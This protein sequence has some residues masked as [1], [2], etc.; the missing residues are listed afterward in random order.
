MNQIISYIKN[1]IN[2]KQKIK[3]TMNK[4]MNKKI[5]S[6]TIIGIAALSLLFFA[7]FQT[8]QAA[9][10]TVQGDLPNDGLTYNVRIYNVDKTGDECTAIGD[11]LYNGN[12]TGNATYNDNAD[13]S[14]SVDIGAGAGTAY[15][16]F[17]QGGLLRASFSKAISGD[18]EIITVDL[19]HVVGTG[20]HADL[21]DKYIAVCSAISE[22]GDGTKVSTVDRQVTAGNALDQWYA[23]DDTVAANDTMYVVLD[24]DVGNN[25]K[26][27][28]TAGEKRWGIKEMDSTGTISTDNY[29]IGVTWAPDTKISSDVSAA[30]DFD[31]LDNAWIDVEDEN[32]ASVGGGF[33]EQSDGG[34]ADDDYYIY[35]DKP[36]AGTN[37][38]E[39]IINVIDAPGGTQKITVWD[40]VDKD[41]FDADGDADIDM[42]ITNTTAKGV[43][44]DADRVTTA[45]L[46]LNG[47]GD[48]ITVYTESIASMLYEIFMPMANADADVIAKNGATTLLTM[49]K[50]LDDTG[51]DDLNNFDMAKLSGNIHD[52]FDGTTDAITIYSDNACSSALSSEAFTFT[53]DTTDT[54]AQY[55]EGVAGTDYF[56]K[57]K[58]D[59]Y[60]ACGY[61]FDPT[62]QAATA[63][64]IVK[65]SGDTHAD[66]LSVLIDNDQG[67]TISNGDVYLKDT[68]NID[69][70]G[71]WYAYVLS[72]ATSGIVYD[73]GDDFNFDSKEVSL[74]WDFSSDIDIDAGSPDNSLSS[75][76]IS[77]AGG[78]IHADMVDAGTEAIQTKDASDGTTALSDNDGAEVLNGGYALYSLVGSGDINIEF[79]TAFGGVVEF[80][81]YN[82]AVTGGSPYI[83]EP[84]FKV[85]ATVPAS[86]LGLEI[87][88]DDL[89]GYHMRDKTAAF[90]IYV[91]KTDEG[92]A[93]YDYRAYTDAAFTAQVLDIS[94]KDVSGVAAWGVNTVT[95]TAI[96]ADVTG[97]TDPVVV[98]AIAGTTGD[99]SGTALS[100]AT[101]QV[102]ANG[103]KKY[104][105]TDA[106]KNLVLKITDG[107]YISCVNT[108]AVTA[109]AGLNNAYS[110]DKKTSGDVDPDVITVYI[111]ADQAGGDDINQTAV[112]G[113]PSTYAILWAGDGASNISFKNVTPAVVLDRTGK[114]LSADATVNV[115]KVSGASQ[116][117]LATLVVY[118]DAACSAAVSSEAVDP[119]IAGYTQY[120]EGV[121]STVYRIAVADA[122]PHTSCFTTG[123]TP[124]LQAATV[125]FDR[126]LSGSVPDVTDT[127][128]DVMSVTADTGDDTYW[129]NTV[130]PGGVPN[131][132]AMYVDDADSDIATST[133]NFRS[134]VAGGGSTLVSTTKD[135]SSADGTVD[136]SVAYGD[137]HADIQVTGE[138]DTVCYGTLPTSNNTDCSTQAGVIT[139]PTGAAAYE[140]YFEQISGEDTYYLQIADS[141]TETYYS[142]NKLTSAT[143]GA[144]TNVEVDGKLSGIVTE[145]YSASVR[146]P[147]VLIGLA[148][149]GSVFP[150]DEVSRTYSYGVTGE[151][152]TPAG[153]YRMYA[154]S[155]VTYDGTASKASYVTSV[156]A[157][158]VPAADVTENWSMVDGIKVTVKDAGA[159]PITDAK[160]DIYTCA[161]ADPSACTWVMG[162]CTQP[163][164]NCTRTGEGT[165]AVAGD[166]LSGDYY[167]A[168]IATGTYIQVRVSDPS[169]VFDTVYSPNSSD[170]VNS[171]V[172]SASAAINPIVVL[173]DPAPEGSITLTGGSGSYLSGENLYVDVGQ[174]VILNV[175]G[176]ETGLT[177]VADL[178]NIGGG[179]TQAV[180]DD[181]DNTYS[182]TQTV[183][184]VATGSKAITVTI[185]DASSNTDVDIVNVTVDNTAPVNATV[186]WTQGGSS[187]DTSEIDTDGNVTWIWTAGSD[188]NSGL[189]NY[190][191]VLQSDAACTFGGAESTVWTKYTTDVSYNVSGLTDG[192]CYRIQVKAVDNVGNIAAA[193][194]NDNDAQV[195]IDT[196]VPDQVV[197]NA[198][199]SA[200]YWI[201]NLLPVFNWTDVAGEDF[202]QIQVDTDMNFSAGTVID[203]STVPVGGTTGDQNTYTAVTSLVSGTSYYWRMRA[204]DSDAA[205]GMWSEI[206]SFTVDNV[207]PTALTVNNPDTTADSQSF[208]AKVT[209]GETGLTCKASF[210]TT[211][212]ASMEYTMA[213]NGDNSY[214]AMVVSNGEGAK[215]VKFECQDAAGNSVT[216][217]KDVAVTYTYPAILSITAP[218]NADSINDATPA[219]DIKAEST[220]LTCKYNLTSNNETWADASWVSL[221]DDTDDTYSSAATASIGSAGLKTIYFKC[222]KSGGPVPVDAV[223]TTFTLDLTG[224]TYTFSAM[225]NS[226]NV[227]SGDEVV[228]YYTSNEDLNS[229]PTV[230]IGAK[231]AVVTR[232]GRLIKASRTLDGTET[233]NNIV[234]TGGTDLAGNIANT[235]T[236]A[237]RISTDFVVPTL[238]TP[239]PADAATDETSPIALSIVAGGSETGLDCRYHISTAKATADIVFGS[240]GYWMADNADGTYGSLIYLPDGTWFVNIKCVDAAGNEGE[241]GDAAGA[242]YSFTV[243]T[244]PTVV[245]VT[246]I[247]AT[248]SWALAN[249]DYDDGWSWDFEVT[250][251]TTEV[252]L[253]M[254]FADWAS[255]DNDILVANN[256]Q[257]YSGE[258]TLAVDA[259]NAIDITAAD[260]YSAVM[261][262]TGDSNTNEAGR[263]IN[264][265]VEA[266]V[267]TGSASGSYSTSYGI[268]TLV[269]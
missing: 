202:Y 27:G 75:I 170:T 199:L 189:K 223:S 40:N 261:T 28:D 260:T 196:S 240:M 208:L 84:L 212:W 39:L 228:A 157:D 63:N 146:V 163:S 185:T 15:V 152:T 22:A 139:S 265:T 153:N 197:L 77:G 108:L 29:G 140:I 76:K 23:I 43:H 2:K 93:D 221:T 173:R 25:C 216:A 61:A 13:L 6:I 64:L 94:G 137:V 68:G 97:D 53:E 248:K 130:D 80:Y 36:D 92:D 60:E 90:I 74:T 264:I 262:L 47:S 255:G 257:F 126:K 37:G 151:V 112:V 184:S 50:D 52:D 246:G 220:G 238:S 182:Y 107:S 102:W 82:F 10:E 215:Q 109:A 91:D 210:D 158:L 69:A 9:D 190:E 171:F 175:N 180:T 104:Y 217:T 117:A 3:I 160:V 70:E 41:L 96:H 174:D 258:A 87:Q 207:L 156:G 100:S 44:S 234:V 219:I 34:A 106:A 155:G 124:S 143:A 59:D 1:K 133:V 213:D 233:D 95:N 206:W 178:T 148:D 55:F 204:I 26:I 254:K 242:G 162:T 19:G 209:S 149:N 21:V 114:V 229:D 188:A 131:T 169:L 241:F 154:D 115:A 99:C 244:D 249:G 86:I 218:A 135:L 56:A 179:A 8:A 98:Y 113:T 165:T 73:T 85:T 227:K 136:A 191:I 89:G 251:P 78:N 161:T 111:D 266:R 71:K 18:E 4:N 38:A 48:T 145:D 269:P 120:F 252:S 226:A 5:F 17:C 203:V 7:G 198:P 138:V 134:L 58:R 236:D 105:E 16:Y 127:T 195:L 186:L 121:D 72:D 187:D 177:V 259:V 79:V 250:V 116:E 232:S 245:T 54:Y 176:G 183:G 42:K 194:L 119:T 66:L 166:G 81:A 150:T 193:Y 51:A 11:L 101:T 225:T 214:Q 181:G 159:N 35:Y 128:I 243:G 267:P 167:F 200:G 142:W 237:S 83:F 268:E 110:I 168:G 20:V 201:T 65:L 122:T 205:D 230:T 118:T 49:S 132:Y 123:F 32:N 256:I 253:K 235:L 222:Q 67:A 263:Q 192:L 129:V 12:L 24:S 224:P 14:E 45:S 141:D 231:V 103:S 247:S 239:T 88:Q 30:A 33:I 46:V 147:E 62:S 164:G 172:T 211:T 31:T 125:N 57:V 144:R